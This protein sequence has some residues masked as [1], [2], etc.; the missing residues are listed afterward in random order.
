LGIHA[1]NRSV[2]SVDD[3]PSR[4]FVLD[5]R[6]SDRMA[7]ALILGPFSSAILALFSSKFFDSLSKSA[8]RRSTASFACFG[9]DGNPV[10]GGPSLAPSA[11]VICLASSW[12]GA[13]KSARKV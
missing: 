7:K 3:D 1:W 10:H 6:I 4:A 13:G 5:S 8:S 9:S 12:K 2:D 11:V